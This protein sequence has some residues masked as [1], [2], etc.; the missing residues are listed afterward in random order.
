MATIFN[1]IWYAYQISEEIW[2]EKYKWIFEHVKCKMLFK[3]N[4]FSWLFKRKMPGFLGY[5]RA[6]HVKGT[7]LMTILTLSYLSLCLLNL[8]T[9]IIDLPMQCR[10]VNILCPLVIIFFCISI[11]KASTDQWPIYQRNGRCRHVH[12]F[13]FL[14]KHSMFSYVV[15]IW[16]KTKTLTDGNDRT[17]CILNLKCMASPPTRQKKENQ[18]L[19]FLK[20]FH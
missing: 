13:K 8:L 12:I 15:F 5:S 2:S 9:S 11:T 17:K 19:S 16:F 3:E 1:C 18:W 14:G 10:L 4:L 6:R 20:V 7:A